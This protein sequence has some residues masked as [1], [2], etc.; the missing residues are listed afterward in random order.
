MTVNLTDSRPD[1]ELLLKQ[2]QYSSEK[3]YDT[4]GKLKIFFGYSAGVGKT[5][6]MLEEAHDL[7]KKGKDIVVGYI[8]PHTRAETMK[9]AEGLETIPVQRI[10]YRSI[11]LNEFDLDAALKRKP[12]IILVDELAHSNAYGVRNKKRYQD[13]EELLNA[14]IDV[15]TTVN[16]QHIESLNDIIK[17]VTR[18]SVR[19][20]VPDYIF[21]YSNK[22][23]LIDIEPEELL[24]RFEEGKVYK[25]DRAATAMN[26]F[27]KRENLD[28]LREISMRR[29]ADRIYRDS[30]SK[31]VSASKKNIEHKLLVLISPSP[32]SAKNIRVTAR[33]AEAYR[34]NWFAVYVETPDTINNGMDE[35][36]S[37]RENM[38]L[39]EQ[40][41]AEVVNLFGDDMALVISKYAEMSGI[42]NIVIGVSR[43]KKGFSDLFREE[44]TDKLMELLSDVEIHIIPDSQNTK[45]FKKKKKVSIGNDFS[46]SW[47]DTIKTA[48]VLCLATL[49]SIVLNDIGVGSQN[50]S[51]LY[52]LSVVVVSRITSGYVYG[53]F[54]SVVGMFGYSAIFTY[55]Y[56]TFNIMKNGF[57]LTFFIMLLIAIITSALT[58][59]NKM[60]NQSAALR[61]QRTQV[62]YDI[63]KKLLVTRGLQNII[64]IINAYIVK[65]LERSV[66]FYS[67]LPS[68]EYVGIM[69]L[70]KGD[71]EAQKFLQTN[72]EK[73]VV[74]WVF[75]NKKRA[76]AGTDTLMG[77]GAYYMPVIAQNK[78]MG[79]IGVSCSKGELTQDNRVFIRMIT[80]QLAMA[81][82]RQRLSDEQRQLSVESEKEKIRSNLLRAISHDLKNPLLEIMN[83]GEKILNS[84]GVLDRKELNKD[85]LYIKEEAQWLA[86]MAENLLSVTMLKEGSMKVKKTPE[87][88]KMIVDEAVSRV[89]E[90]FTYRKININK[91]DRE[92][93][94]PMDGT[95][96]E[97]VIINLLENSIKHSD[98]GSDINISVKKEN[99]SAVFTVEDFGDGIAE[100][101]LPHI[102]EGFDRSLKYNKENASRTTGIG[103][104]ICTTII[105]A[106]SGKIKAINK[107]EAGAVIEFRIPM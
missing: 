7:I 81:L 10:K 35:I 52:I 33:M 85:A 95:L 46:L 88:V 75:T 78:V 59:R 16:V 25:A 26:N 77:A 47:T 14:G 2:V 32:S 13:V 107:K 55:P 80:S 4:K 61:E 45:T 8:E 12:E 40:L 38:A 6:A 24:K 3:K 9:L 34:A 101:E 36:K 57:P 29:T 99:K 79:V 56:F 106:H 60:Q 91:I 74:N 41:G 92:M 63:N 17:D 105:N 50:I 30:S 84:N 48:I 53:I 51:M 73:A 82:G 67:E 5:Y 28:T 49:I 86:R 93:T 103:L 96:I 98:S 102:F 21:D 97:Q 44:F 15:Y 87:N 65:L 104:S 71:E 23:E 22:V 76:G 64:E 1:P 11:M 37:L 39:A 83:T 18:I 68:D 27:F 89:L 90:R 100:E 70:A 20:T 66:I 62:L 94:V 19:E 58:V 72:D 54:S 43:R 69:T 31:N 42:T